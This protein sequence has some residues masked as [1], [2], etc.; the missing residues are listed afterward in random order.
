[1]KF[2]IQRGLLLM[3]LTGLVW[4]VAGCASTDPDNASSRPWN[5]PTGW[6]HGL[7]VGLNEGR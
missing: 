5:T 3:A 2:L 6:E 4:M 7:P 1:M